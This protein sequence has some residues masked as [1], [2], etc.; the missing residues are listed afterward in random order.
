MRVGILALQGAFRMHAE[1][2]DLL[3]GEPSEIRSPED[4]DVD[5]LVLPG[6]ESTTISFL[7][8]SSELREPIS[9]LLSNGMPVLGTCAGLILLAR[10]VEGARSD[11]TSFGL[12]D[13]VV[14][15]NAY[16]SQLESFEAD[17]P[18]PGSDK[19]FR[20]V[21]IRAPIIEDVGA[22]VEVLSRC[23]GRPVL[24]AQGSVVAATFHPEL[25][26]D[27]RV[28]EIFL[29]RVESREASES[30]IARS[31]GVGSQRGRS[32]FQEETN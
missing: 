30:R 32:G 24:V 1:M 11:Q 16:G 5:A 6:G 22:Q 25:A 13:C 29:A 31:V 21:F 9:E 27:S 8:D 10:E 14:R 28:H 19:P 26:G 17:L 18:L 7:L 4:L 2:I 12:L 3:G 23:E 15:R 20:G